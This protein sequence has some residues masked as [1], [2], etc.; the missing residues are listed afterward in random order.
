VVSVLVLLAIAATLASFARYY[1][2]SQEPDSY[3]SVLASTLLQAAVIVIGGAMI[4]GLLGLVEEM[5]AKRERAR[6]KRLELFRRMRAAHVHIAHAQRLIRADDDPKSY[7]TQ[8]QA[9]MRV[10][11]ELEEIREEVKVSGRLYD[12]E[13]RISIM[14]G[15]ARI[16]LFLEEG[17][18][19]YLAWCNRA[20]G[21]TGNKHRT[22]RWVAELIEVRGSR[23]PE[24]D[25]SDESW[26]PPDSMPTKYDEGLSK[27]KLRMRAYVYGPSRR[28]PIDPAEQLRRGTRNA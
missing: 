1:Y 23:E 10:T 28:R 12:Q 22:N 17:S 16:I 8:M 24:L 3:Q 11:R 25:P 27:S 5:R 4:A 19:E 21:G 18:T 20:A 7:G 6:A 9:L 2:D 13:D 15:I 14:E 26:A